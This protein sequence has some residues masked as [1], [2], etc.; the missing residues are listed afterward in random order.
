MTDVT[1]TKKPKTKKQYRFSVELID[2]LL[3]QIEK[4]GAES[5]LG[6]PGRPAQKEAG[7][8]YA[9]GRVDSPPRH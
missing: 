2:Q 3:A 4:K 9:D 1:R 5:I 7:R 6:A 8:A